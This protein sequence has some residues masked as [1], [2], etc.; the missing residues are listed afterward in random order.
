[1]SYTSTPLEVRTALCYD[2]NDKTRSGGVVETIILS[3][4]ELKNITL[5]ADVLKSGGLVA[6][7]AETVYGLGADALDESAVS[8]IFTA[9]GRQEDNPLIV[10]VASPGD[11]RPLVHT[12][13]EIFFTLAK[14]FWPGAL[15]LVMKKSEK[16]PDNVTAGLDTVAIRMPEHPAALSLI[17]AFGSPVA[18]PSANLSGKPSPTSAI[19]VL[20]DI[21]GK[22][23]Y[24][25][26]G[27]DC[28]VGV[29][30]TVLDISGKTP[31]ILRPGGV[32]YNEIKKVLGDIKVEIA[33][34][35]IEA[36]SSPMSPGMKYRHYAPKAPLTA[37]IGPPEKTAKYISDRIAGKDSNIAALMFDDYACTHPNVITFGNSDDYTTQAI[38]LFDALRN[39]DN[40][41][42]TSIYAQVPQEEELGL[43]IANRIKKAAGMNIVILTT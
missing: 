42:I 13:P 25:L 35:S 41:A 11:V 23:P 8:K 17:R 5:C 37:I 27:G 22:I 20:N 29:E 30:S 18:A 43:A 14:A 38:R 9:K 26:D 1:M 7:P 19:H 34:S 36:S 32:T 10:H 2:F 24:I 3:A 15:T 4:N 31:R 39:F 21:S 33:P 28:T 40:M 12:I 6:F 16:V